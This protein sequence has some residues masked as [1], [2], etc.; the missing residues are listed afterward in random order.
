MCQPPAAGV[1]VLSS[2]VPHL[3]NSGPACQFPRSSMSGH[4]SRAAIHSA[5]GQ[6]EYFFQVFHDQSVILKDLCQEWVLIDPTAVGSAG[7]TDRTGF[8]EAGKAGAGDAGGI[9]AGGVGRNGVCDA[10]GLP[11][12]APARGTPVWGVPVWCDLLSPE[13]STGALP[14]W[15]LSCGFSV[16]PTQTGTKFSSMNIDSPMN[17]I[18]SKR[19]PHWWMALACSQRVLIPR[20]PSKA[21]SKSR[22]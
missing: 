18:Y 2:S 13:T 19:L 16:A 3:V 7:E 12:S 11:P 5:T 1:A 9:G 8:G 21:F 6:P 22:D 17:R 20:S 14:V 15:R 4:H 10:R